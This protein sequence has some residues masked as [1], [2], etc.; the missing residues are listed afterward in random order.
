VKSLLL[1]VELMNVVGEDVL[2]AAVKSIG[3]GI[4]Y[5]PADSPT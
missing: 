2:A 5:S 4:R 1:G 3:E